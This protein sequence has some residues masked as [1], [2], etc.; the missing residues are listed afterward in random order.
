MNLSDDTYPKQSNM[1]ST[2][3]DFKLDKI[4]TGTSLVETTQ[5]RAMTVSL[6]TY[7]SLAA[8]CTQNHMCVL[9]LRVTATHTYS[10]SLTLHMHL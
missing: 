1:C 8:L 6:H 9:K 5:V 2:R 4:S 3:F 10:H 7:I